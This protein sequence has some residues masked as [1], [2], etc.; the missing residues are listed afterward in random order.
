[1]VHH[2]RGIEAS[3]TQT[4]GNGTDAFGQMMTQ[5]PP[6]LDCA[7]ARTP[8]GLCATGLT[9][10]PRR[11]LALLSSNSLCIWTDIQALKPFAATDVSTAVLASPGPGG[12]RAASMRLS[13]WA[14]SGLASTIGRRSAFVSS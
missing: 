1:M 4:G 2:D 13:S 9:D 8:G 12:S 14:I 7:R 10:G 3:S 11:H 5:S 6:A